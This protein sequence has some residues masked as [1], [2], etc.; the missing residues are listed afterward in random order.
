M[1]NI[2]IFKN[3]LKYSLTFHYG[4]TGPRVQPTK[5]TSVQNIGYEYI[6]M[7][8]KKIWLSAI[9]KKNNRKFKKAKRRQ[10]KKTTKKFD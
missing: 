2:E 4:T 9:T 1:Q 7:M 10:K 6:C 5:E 8:N 3:I